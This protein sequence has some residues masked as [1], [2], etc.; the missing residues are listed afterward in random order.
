MAA[1]YSQSLM[2]L[3]QTLFEPKLLTVNDLQAPVGAQQA[4]MSDGNSFLCKNPDG[5]QGWYVFDAERSIPG[6]PPVLRA[7]FP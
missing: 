3:N 7:L 4:A 6:Y 5:S 2:G 1:T